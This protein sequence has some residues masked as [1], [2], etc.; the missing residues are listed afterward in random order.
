MEIFLRGCFPRAE[1]E[2]GDPNHMG[3]QNHIDSSM[4]CTK[5]PVNFG[6]SGKFL[7]PTETPLCDKYIFNIRAEGA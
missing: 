4:F 1:V 5:A 7:V 3:M 2:L 6:L